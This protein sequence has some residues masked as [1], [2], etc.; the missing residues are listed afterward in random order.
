MLPAPA[1]L[2]SWWRAESNANDA[3]DSNNG[4]LRGGV[5]FTTGRVSQAFRFNGTNS[6]V[7]V[8]DSPALRLTNQ[9]T[10][11]FWVRR[12]DL[13]KEDYII[14][15][16]GDYTRGML[17]YG[18]TITQPQWGGTFAFTFAG[19][20]RHSSSITDLNWHHCAVTA[21]NGDVDPIFY[22]D[23]V[24]RPVTLRQG[25]STIRL[26]ASTAALDIGAQVDPVSGWFYYSGALVDELSIYN[27]ALTAAEIQAI[28]NAD[29]AGKCPLGVA[30]S[31]ITQ[32]AGQTVFAGSSA[33]FTVI[34]AGSP[35]LGYQ[36]RKGGVALLGST[37]PILEL[38]N[39]TTNDSGAYDVVISNSFGA[40]TSQV[41]TLTVRVPSAQALLNV[42]FAAYSQVKVGF[43][44]TGQTPIDFWNN[45]TAPWQSFAWLSNLVAADGSPTSVGLTVQNGAGHW[46]FT[47]PDLMYNCFCYSQDNGDITLTVTNLPS[48]D[49]DFYLYGHSGAANGNTV[50]QLLV[51]GVDYGNLPTGTHADSLSTNWVEGAQYVIYRNVTVTNG[52]APVTI[53][54][55]PG[56]SGYALLNGMQ[57]GT[58]PARAPFI[59]LQPTDQI[60]RAGYAASFSVTANG[61]RPLNYQWRKDGVALLGSTN[62]ILE[63]SN[64]T[65]NDSGAYDV[66]IS[67]SFGAVTS[68]VATLAVR[69]PSAQALLNVNFAAYSQVKLGF[70][71]T[72]QTPIDFWNNYTAPWQSFAWLSNL[73]AAD[74]SPT[75]VGL[76][77][78]NGAGHWSF[79]H[80]DLMYNCFCYSQDNGDITLT[81]TNLPSG[82]YDFYLYGHS[83]AANGNTVFQLL[84]DGVNYGNLPTGTNAD[85]LS[86]N[87]VEAAQYV[88][89]RKVAV[90]N[91]GAPVTIKAHP[92]LSG[93]ALLN[94]MQIALANR[95]PVA[96]CADA[97]V[98]AGTNCQAG[99]SVN[100]GSFD[101]DGDPITVSQV[102]PAPYPVG[103]NRVTLTV[104]DNHGASNSCSALVIVQD[105][106]PPV[107]ICASNKVVECGTAWSF[108]PAFAFD[109]C[110]ATNV[111]ISVVSTVTNAGCG[112]T[113]A[114]TRTWQAED[115]A[116]NTATCSQTVTVLDTTPPAIVCPASMTLEFQGENGAVAPYVVT[117][118][119]TCSSVS[120]AVTP[121]SGSVFPIGV[122]PVRATAMDACTNVSQCAF[123]VTVLGAQGVKSNVLAE[124]IALRASVV[125]TEAFA[126]KFD[127]AIQHLANSLDPAYWLDQTHLH[128]KSGNAAMNEEKLA[129]NKLAEIMESKD[130]PVDPA[131]LQGLID[132]IVRCD[133]LLA[134]ISVQEAANA[135]LNPRKVEQDLAMVAKGDSEAA[136]GH[137]ANAIEHYRNAWRHAIQLRVQVDLNPDGTT[138]VQ[139]VGNNS[140]SYLIEVSTDMLTWVSLGACTSRPRR[141]R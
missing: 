136:A 75:S 60:V 104:S 13:Q 52:G 117:A 20:A 89:Y 58:S 31:I 140:K 8:P 92:G 68:Q 50:F 118:S 39:T 53:K 106:T 23:G 83:G 128:A 21:R 126:Q 105:R 24:Q 37:N 64:T 15:K 138:R 135:G 78:Q 9:L 27:R 95:A 88:V 103:T 34:A 82:E 116:G 130:C 28:Y 16:G 5:S 12:Q 93:Y 45:Y 6:Y 48:G 86:T 97:V 1:G 11:E 94:G 25:A 7:E 32:P 19:G 36:W 87:W 113:F 81:V 55:H 41:A 127:A 54:A 47:H 35:P 69:V 121:A 17:N 61:T 123:T 114:A 43:A 73:V 57:I 137:C 134:V 40:V 111:F 22:V 110:S 30:P 84:V 72:G 141:Q 29:G 14:N 132:R 90:T 100:N 65:T 96:L 109:D 46:S 125:L 26:Y 63:L 42:N 115:G 120:L 79:T 99:A 2:V 133:R 85:S 44:G 3:A 10:I 122:T 67:N 70:A 71:G 108:D 131:V 18:V 129:A 76:T 119:D 80:P 49:Y 107:I 4:T 91:G 33:T 102:P 59:S 101:P 62:P 51:D 56:L 124:L 139:F 66:V 38:S 112:S 74:G 77:V 98:A